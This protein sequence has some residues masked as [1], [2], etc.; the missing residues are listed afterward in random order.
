MNIGCVLDSK[1]ELGRF[2]MLAPYVSIVGG[3]HVFSI[4]GLP[5]IFSGR[6]NQ[7]R[8][9]VIEDDAW[10]GFWGNYPCQCSD[11]TRGNRRCRLGGDEGYT[12]LRDLAGVPARKVGKRFA[13]P[14]DRA[15][16][17]EMLAGPVVTAEFCRPL[18]D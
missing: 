6:P 17:D 15:R 13:D 14:A 10:I 7:I 9:T 3:D 2:A 12:S 11:W 18:S 8:T 5:V 16:H 1:V 4:P